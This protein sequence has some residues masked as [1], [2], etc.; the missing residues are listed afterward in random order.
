MSVTQS[1]RFKID[2]LLKRKLISSICYYKGDAHHWIAVSSTDGNHYIFSEKYWGIGVRYESRGAHI[3]VLQIGLVNELE[4]LADVR[5]QM[6]IN[7]VNELR[8]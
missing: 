5:L 2:L 4:E 7:N 3:R 1:P 6:G 8:V